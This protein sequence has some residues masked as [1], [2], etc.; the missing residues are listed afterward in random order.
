MLGLFAIPKNN[1]KCTID[2]IFLKMFNFIFYFT[3]LISALISTI[4]NFHFRLMNP[5]IFL[6]LYNQ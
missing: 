6:I 5:F 1:K 2:C 3:N 4:E